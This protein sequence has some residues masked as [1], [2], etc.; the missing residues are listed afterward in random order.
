MRSRIFICAALAGLGLVAAAGQAA[1]APAKDAIP[2]LTPAANTSWQVNFWDYLLEP[3]AGVAHGPI[4]TDPAYPYN[5][6]IQN[7]ALYRD[8]E[9]TTAIVNAKDPVLK[10]WAAKEM[11]ASN[12]ELLSG[13]KKLSFRAQSR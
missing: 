13:K 4:K 11:Q 10:P 7:G 3:P 1:S 12:E 6:Q 8:G 9:L 2:Q 5:S